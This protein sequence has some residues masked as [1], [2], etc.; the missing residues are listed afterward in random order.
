MKT[1]MLLGSLILMI[2][3]SAMLMTTD[4]AAAGCGS[5][6]GDQSAAC[7]IATSMPATAQSQP[8]AVVN[9]KCPIMGTKIDPNKVP[10]NL[11]REFK[12]QKVGFCCGG[13]P[14]A[15]DKLTDAEKEAKLNASK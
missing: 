4:W 5:C 10:A 12:G 9:T 14:A 7:A 15:W 8:V 2:F 3:G 13:C 6:G 11:I 1:G